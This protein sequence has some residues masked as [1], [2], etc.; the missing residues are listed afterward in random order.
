MA[1]SGTGGLPTADELPEVLLDLGV[2]HEDINELVALRG[3]L[4]KDPAAL[5]SLEERLPALADGIGA[6]D[7]PF[8]L[9]EPPRE[10]EALG[11]FFHLFVYLAA[12][13]YVLDYHQRHGIPRDISRRTLAD[14]G[15]SVAAHRRWKGTGGLRYPRWL[16]F[17]FRGELYQLGRLQFQRARLGTRTGDGMAAAGLPYAPG[18]PCLAIHIPDCYGPLT[19][20]A[21]DHSM[22]LARAFFPRHF[23][24]ERYRIAVL[25]SWVLDRQLAR[26]LPPDANLIR[27]QERFRT[28]YESAEPADGDPLAF[29]F[30]SADRPLDTL[31]RHTTLQRALT[32]HLRSGGHWYIGHGWLPL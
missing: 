24:D 29:V 4:L 6:L 1:T 13:P 7:E 16:R 18:D 12:L 3:V 10:P 30:G 2:P 23:P 28:A 11:R 14:L 15:R 21:C 22:A 9:P 27:F 31:P 20:E 25:H 32:D 19:P 26:Y 5:R 8:Q 17:H